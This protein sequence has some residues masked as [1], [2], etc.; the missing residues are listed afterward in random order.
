MLSFWPNPQWEGVMLRDRYDPMDLFALVPKL[1]LAM[2]PELAQIDQL[3]EDDL[4]FQQVKADLLK[5][6]PNTATLGRYSTPVEVILRMLVVKRLYRWSYEETEHFVSDSIVLRQFC[7]LYLEPVPDDTTLI[8]WVHLIGPETLQ[9]LNDRVVELAGSLKV[10]RGRK[11]RVDSTVVP[12]NIHHPT[13]SALLEDGVRVLSRLLRR[14]KIAL[15][16][17]THL[18]REAFRSRTRSVRRLVQQAHRLARRQGGG[19]EGANAASLSTADCSGSAESK[20]GSQSKRGTGNSIRETGPR[21]GTAT[22]RVSA[23]AGT[24]HLP[25]GTSGTGWGGSAS[26]GENRQPL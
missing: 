1:S 10:T 8:R 11:L 26:P 24:D 7:R 9:E 5:R 19:K 17:A 25:N 15:E 16:P 14:A 4:L 2:D 18:G 20:P 22:G 23:L 21:V 13:D 3:L 6:Y 12:T